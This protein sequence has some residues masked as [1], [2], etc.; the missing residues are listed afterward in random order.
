MRAMIIGGDNVM[1]T[2]RS[3][4][5]SG[6]AD[7][8][9]WSGRKRSDLRRDMPCGVVHMVIMLNFVNHNLARRM[10]LLAQQQQISVAYV[11][12]KQHGGMPH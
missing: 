11:G 4:E 12:R 5:A 8:V 9:H 2:R 10:K 7:I 3:L 6:Y 1:V